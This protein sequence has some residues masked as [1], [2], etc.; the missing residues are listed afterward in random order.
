MPRIQDLM[1]MKK[2]KWMANINEQEVN[3][4]KKCSNIQQIFLGLFISLGKI[5]LSI[6]FFTKRFL[7]KT[8]IKRMKMVFYIHVP[9]LHLRIPNDVISNKE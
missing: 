1:E 3:R 6:V 7:L 4:K 5:I 8:N 9:A 2:K